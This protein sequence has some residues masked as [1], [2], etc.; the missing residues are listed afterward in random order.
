[1]TGRAPIVVCMTSS[2]IAA[3][4]LRKAFGDK[5]VLDGIDLDVREGTVFSLL[6]PNGAGKTTAVNVL[7]TLMKADG[8]T[9]RVAGHDI[10]AEAKAV[11]DKLPAE[12]KEKL[13]SANARF[14]AATKVLADAEA[15]LKKAELRSEERRV[16][17][18]CERLCRSRWSPYH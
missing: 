5:V 3:S 12:A 10:A 6:G 9:V 4:G 18:E 1:M 14:I 15:A 2:A 7:T 8:G 17:K 16:G 11:L 13:K